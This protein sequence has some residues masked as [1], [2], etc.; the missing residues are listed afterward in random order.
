MFCYIVIVVFCSCIVNILSYSVYLVL[1]K[2]LKT[3]CL[4]LYLKDVIGVRI[5]LKTL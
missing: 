4:I 1:E 5:L 3:E 2:L